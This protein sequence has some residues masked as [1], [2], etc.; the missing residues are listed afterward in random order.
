VV[1]K[2]ADDYG[3]LERTVL[4]KVLT[5]GE[6]QELIQLASVSCHGDVGRE[7]GREGGGGGGGGVFGRKLVRQS[8]KAVL[9]NH[10]VPK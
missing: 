9:L 2:T 8:K 7:G 1:V 6:C 4:D 10:P 3:G 5:D